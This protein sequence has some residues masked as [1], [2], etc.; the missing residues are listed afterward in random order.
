MVIK[1]YIENAIGT[2]EF[3]IMIIYCEFYMNMCSIFKIGIYIF[4]GLKVKKVKKKKK[5]KKK[6]QL[7]LF[8]IL[9]IISLSL[10]INTLT[11]HFI[12]YTWLIAW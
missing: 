1:K 12:R 6:Q 10:Y 9:Y 11:G 3:Y 7:Y 8:N 2:F 5:S 4:M